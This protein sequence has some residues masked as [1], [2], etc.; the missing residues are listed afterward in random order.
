M[1]KWDDFIGESATTSSRSRPAQGKSY[2]GLQK[3]DA[4]AGPVGDQTSNVSASTRTTSRPGKGTFAER[5]LKAGLKG[6]GREKIQEREQWRGASGRQAIVPPVVDKARPANE[7]VLLPS[8][9]NFWNPPPGNET[10]GNDTTPTPTPRASA[11]RTGPVPD[12][13]E[14][15]DDDVKPTPPLKVGRNS[16]PRVLT[17]SGPTSSNAPDYSTLNKPPMTPPT[18]SNLAASSGAIENDFRAAMND[19]H[20][21][22]QPGSRFSATT[23]D[24]GNTHDSLPAS[25]MVH[26]N[27]A[28]SNRNLPQTAFERSRATGD[29]ASIRSTTKSIARKPTPAH[30]GASPLASDSPGVA[31]K[32][33][34]QSPP[35]A[36]SNDLITSLQA[37]LDGL[38]HRRRNLQRIIHDLSKSTLPTQSTFASRREVTRKADGYKSELEEV[39]A[40]QHELGLKL[41]R[42]LRRKDQ[43]MEPTGL[44][45]RRVTG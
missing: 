39:L 10:H 13:Y 8:T 36:D 6:S 17:P 14:D 3:H 4:A 24:T 15:H 7:P 42:A 9:R 30:M 22:T 43:N 23:Y 18:Q 31:A 16:P 26:G 25:P 28:S 37:Q 5:A 21:S 2:G 34:P 33:L 29:T 44:W 19:M 35:E 20:L 32:S 11:F 45:V 27:P 41:H 12:I 38:N 1:T 40:Q